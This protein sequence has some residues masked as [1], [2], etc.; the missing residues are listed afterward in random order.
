MRTISKREGDPGSYTG[1]WTETNNAHGRVQ[2]GL[3]LE[4]VGG[5][6]F[7][8]EGLRCS[9]AHSPVMGLPSFLVYSDLGNFEDYWSGVLYNVPSLGS[10]GVFSSSAW[11]TD[12]GTKTREATCA[13]HHVMPGVCD[14]NTT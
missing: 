3:I 9:S 6:D 4:Y 13:S 1:G 8:E 11:D 10:A 7:W 14:M 5:Q 2:V 12:S